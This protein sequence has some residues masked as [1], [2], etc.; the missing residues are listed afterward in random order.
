MRLHDAPGLEGQGVGGGP[1]LDQGHVALV[2]THH[3][4]E[5]LRRQVEVAVGNRA[6]QGQGGFHQIH[7]LLEQLLWQVRFGLMAAGR[8]GH[9]ALDRAGPTGPVHLHA[10][11][12][13]ILAVAAGGVDR[14]VPRHQAV[15]AA[16]GLGHQRR[17]TAGETHRQHAGIEQGHQPADRPGEAAVPL[18]P[19]H[20]PTALEAFNPGRHQLRE[21]A[22]RVTA[23]LHHQGEH[24]WSLG[25]VAHL[26]GRWIH[27]AA[28]GKSHRRRAGCSVLEGLGGRR[29]LAFLLSIRLACRQPLHHQRQPAGGAG[30]LEG[31]EGQPQLLEI[32]PHLL[33]QLGQGQA[34]EISREL[35]S[36]DLQQKGGHA[37]RPWQPPTLWI[38]PLPAVAEIDA[39]PPWV[40]ACSLRSGG[41]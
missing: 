27:A 15:A 19:T 40:P 38:H 1:A 18:P 21:Q 16:A 29:P 10:R 33:L 34:G 26:Q 12:C 24:E 37:G 23:P 39:G 7:Q 14:H 6:L 17:V 2:R 31:G 41:P 13:Q 25:R 30:D 11:H 32:A 20:E 8:C 4:A 35:L 3:G 36:S 22:G 28:P 9:R 5:H